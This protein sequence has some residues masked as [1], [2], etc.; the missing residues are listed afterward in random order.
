M[1]ELDAMRPSKMMNEMMK[2]VFVHWHKEA[3][4]ECRR[5]LSSAPK[6]RRQ[7]A[8]TWEGTW[9]RAHDEPPAKKFNS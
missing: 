9:N 4:L 1:L 3:A 5:M 2:R 8:S 7:K 6:K